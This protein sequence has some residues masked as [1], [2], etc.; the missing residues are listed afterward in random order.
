MWHAAADQIGFATAGVNRVT[1]NNS[2]ITGTL[3]GNAST[4]STLQTARTISLT[5]AV[6]GS[7]S[8]NGGS[9]ISIATSSAGA[10]YYQSPLTT[11]SGASV[12]LTSIPSWVK[13]IT[14][15]FYGASNTVASNM[16]VRLGTSAGLI[17]TGYSSFSTRSAQTND[18]RTQGSNGTGFNINNV[19][20]G[21]FYYGHMWISNVGS[22][23][24]VQSHNMVDHVSGALASVGWKDL[25]ATLTQIAL[26]TPS[27]TWDAGSFSAVYEG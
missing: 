16:Y 23:L 13:R 5:G 8:F 22:N 10:Q 26:V 27:G 19:N 11:L 15:I 25:G 6:T 3:N 24:W 9:N 21:W 18:V 4:A 14:I 7:A 2:G 1:I 17:A 20:A 12:S